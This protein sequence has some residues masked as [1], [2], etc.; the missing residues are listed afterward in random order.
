MKLYNVVFD[1]PQ[2]YMAVKNAAY[3]G[4]KKAMVTINE[5][6]GQK[7]YEVQSKAAAEAIVATLGGELRVIDYDV[8]SIYK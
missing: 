2:S 3:I 7:V 4:D 1:E 8:K 6:T 5:S